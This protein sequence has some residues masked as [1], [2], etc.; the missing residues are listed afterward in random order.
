MIGYVYK[1]VC[2]VQNTP[3][4]IGATR[5]IKTRLNGHINSTKKSN[6][7]LYVYLRENSIIPTIEVLEELPVSEIRASEKKWLHRLI[8]EGFVLYNVKPINKIDSGSVKIDP[9]VYEEIAKHCA[10]NGIKVSFFMT[11]A[12][13]EKLEKETQKQ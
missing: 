5:N 9:S 2:P 13:K 3:I 8:G 7:P 4:Y 12:G 1:L 11:Q 6:L 10:A